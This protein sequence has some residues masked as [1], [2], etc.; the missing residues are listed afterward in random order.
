[1]TANLRMGALVDPKAPSDSEAIA[2]DKL[3]KTN[4]ATYEI[5]KQQKI[6]HDRSSTCAH[7]RGARCGYSARRDLRGGR[8]ATDVVSP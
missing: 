3:D 5:I 7:L 1:M 4:A 6:N 8:R 2:S